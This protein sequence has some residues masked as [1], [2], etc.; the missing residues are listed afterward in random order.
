MP[1]YHSNPLA[2]GDYG[3]GIFVGSVVADI[4]RDPRG[5]DGIEDVFDRSA[6]VP[7][8]QRA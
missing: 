8:H 1:N 5:D 6:F 7:R 4:E 2:L 3:E